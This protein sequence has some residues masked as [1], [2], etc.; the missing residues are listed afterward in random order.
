MRTNKVAHILDNA[1]DIH[2]HLA[3]H[4]DSFAGILQRNIGGSRNH[5]GTGQGNRLHQRKRDVART[6]R[7]IHD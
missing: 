7:Q 6:R 3:E 4:L 2:L 1:D 5:N